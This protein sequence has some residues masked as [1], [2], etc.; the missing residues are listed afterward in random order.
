[1]PRSGSSMIARTRPGSALNSSR[2]KR[3]AGKLP[4]GT[5]AECEGHFFLSGR[6]DLILRQLPH[7]I[8]RGCNT[9]LEF[10]NA[11][12]GIRKHRRFHASELGARNNRVPDSLAYLTSEV[13][14]VG[15]KSRVE[16]NRGID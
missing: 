6:V 16:Q 2:A 15:R 1:M 11:R 12:R 13:V 10:G 7:E 14:H 5:I 4:L 3:L 8:D 9:L